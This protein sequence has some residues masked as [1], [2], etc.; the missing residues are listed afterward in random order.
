MLDPALT[1][2]LLTTRE[3]AL[4]HQQ[5]AGLV[6]MLGAQSRHERIRQRF[7][8]RLYLTR[9]VLL[10]NPRYAT[11]WIH[12]YESKD[13][14]AYITTMGFNVATFEFLQTSGFSDVWDSTPIPQ[15]DTSSS[16]SLQ[17]IF[18]LVPATTSRYLDFALD[19][20]LWTLQSLPDASI[21][22]PRSLRQYEYLSSLIEA[23]HP[24]LKGVFGFLDRWKTPIFTPGDP[25][26]ENLTYSGWYHD[27][28][29]SSVAVFDSEGLIIANRTNCP[30][31]W[32]D[33]RIA[34]PIYNKLISQAPAGFSLLS[35]TAFPRTER[36]LRGRIIAPLKSGQRLPVDLTEKEA[37]LVLNREIVTAHQAAKWG[38]RSI[39]STFSRLRVPL[40]ANDSLCC[41]RIFAVVLQLHNLRVQWV[42]I[43]QIHSV[44]V[45]TWYK[46]PME[47]AVWEGF[48]EMVFGEMRHFDRVARF[49]VVAADL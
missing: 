30:S 44:Y 5:A 15:A 4:Q 34:R 26:V 29:V 10:P 27:H 48:E 25:E 39:Q 19:I 43:S 24:L 41:Q 47:K 3:E 49:H 42:G 11:P 45:S 36:A 40:D 12:L 17:Q 23:Q 33:A 31:S 37:I 18:A 20:L 35:D 46:L 6:V 2:F 38:M 8:Q 7:Q 13:N 21:T 14:R 16:K 22:I 1:Y 32:H 28:Y 9:P